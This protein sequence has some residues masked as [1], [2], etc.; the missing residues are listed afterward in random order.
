[1]RALIVDDEGGARLEIRRLLK[2]HSDIEVIAERLVGVTPRQ[3]RLS[4]KNA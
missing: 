4:A 3:F 1:V 2:V